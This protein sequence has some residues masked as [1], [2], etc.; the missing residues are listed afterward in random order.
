MPL[1]KSL[2]LQGALADHPIFKDIGSS[3]IDSLAPSSFKS[4]LGRSSSSDK[5][6]DHEVFDCNNVLAARDTE[7]F[8]AVGKQ[9]RC[10][11]FL[12]IEDAT[13]K[14]QPRIYKTLSVPN[15]DFEIKSLVLNISGTHMAIVGQSSIIICILPPPGFLKDSDS[16]IHCRGRLL[17]NIYRANDLSIRKVLWHPLS[18]HD[19]SLVVL[20]SDAVIRMFDIMVSYTEPDQILDLSEPEIQGY[21]YGFTDVSGIIPASM[22][23][24][25]KDLYTG[26][27]T[28]YILAE[29]GDIY[30]LCPFIPRQCVVERQSIQGLLEWALSEYRECESYE[31][32]KKEKYRRRNQ[33]NWIADIADQSASMEN[34]IHLSQRTDIYNDSREY[35]SFD[36]PDSMKYTLKL[37]GPLVIR[38]YPAELYK[39]GNSTD[40][41]V[42]SL[43]SSAIVAVTSSLG[44]ISFCLQSSPVSVS[45]E[46]TTREH[47]GKAMTIEK[48]YEPTLYLIESISLETGHKPQ[49][50]LLLHISAI[51]EFSLII[52]CACLV[53]SVDF[54]HW[55]DSLVN[56]I[57]SGMSD[58]EMQKLFASNLSSEVSWL[59]L[60]HSKSILGVTQ[61]V[62]MSSDV[63][64]VLKSDS[65]EFYEDTKFS[66][67]VDANKE[68][69][70]GTLKQLDDAPYQ[71]FMN[72]ISIDVDKLR[73]GCSLRNDMI[74]TGSQLSVSFTEGIKFDEDS[75]KFFGLMVEH[76]DKDI[77]ELYSA[78]L[79]IY[80]RLSEQRAELHRQ[81]S[82]LA[83]VQDIIERLEKSDAYLKIE[84]INNNQ[85]QLKEKADRI[86][87]KMLKSNVVPLSDA[88]KNW[89]QE[90][91]RVKS[92]IDDVHGISS[93][94]QQA[95]SQSGRLLT[96]VEEFKGMDVKT[97][98]R[99]PIGLQSYQIQQLKTSLENE[100]KIINMTKLKL[101]KLF[102]RVN[103]DFENLHI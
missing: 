28:L 94:N 14:G 8:L 70:K 23:F 27:M 83:N 48:M 82:R 64:I 103:D 32:S 4:L 51:N 47:I 15:L 45:W 78:G 57:S 67:A 34:I 16:R 50:E 101:E 18:K 74:K 21:S 13:I 96:M 46:S 7:L 37:Q 99:S 43:A 59:H 102:Q 87:R 41:S 66:L 42:F 35:G 49:S 79:C 60:S 30:V 9:I 73:R 56:I 44:Q 69:T 33:L 85:M 98:R 84:N 6:G 65:V 17:S 38:P 77:A 86:Y 12:N 91:H 39:T 52:S 58:N 29:N 1:A 20:S 61:L 63:L 72:P 19:T 10:T 31:I 36:R 92:K 100:S 75:L 55:K 88:E 22:C 26:H 2:R 97:N 11:D 90:L 68:T 95:M 71:T 5:E 53:V 24:G 62:S 89:V 54:G 40:I 3:A 25:P 93:R 80:R 81:L 76:A